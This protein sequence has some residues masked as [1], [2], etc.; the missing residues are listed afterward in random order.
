MPE[1]D[2][3]AEPFLLFFFFFFNALTQAVSSVLGLFPLPNCD[4]MHIKLGLMGLLCGA[5]HLSCAQ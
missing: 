5:S 4:Q 3:E 1:L 2:R